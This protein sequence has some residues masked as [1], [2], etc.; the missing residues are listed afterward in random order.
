M[1]C[2]V[3]L[4]LELFQMLKWEGRF[5]PA[6]QRCSVAWQA[7][8]PALFFLFLFW[9]NVW[10]VLGKGSLALASAERLHVGTS[11]T[12]VRKPLPGTGPGQILQ[13]GLG[14][15]WKDSIPGNSKFESNKSIH[16]LPGQLMAVCI[17]SWWGPGN[18]QLIKSLAVVQRGPVA[19]NIFIR[20]YEN[21]YGN[22]GVT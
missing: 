2:L 11:V 1:L 21:Q 10:G 4:H 17:S 8:S 9:K 16:F 20:I 19:A 22:F 6:H 18:L 12:S 7:Q 14:L 15:R 5:L 3:S 13:R